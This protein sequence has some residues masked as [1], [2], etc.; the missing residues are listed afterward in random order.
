MVIKARLRIAL[1]RSGKRQAD[2]ARHCNVTTSAVNQ[3]IKDNGRE[4]IRLEHDNLMC[5][6]DLLKVS[7]DWLTGKTNNMELITGGPQKQVGRT[8]VTSCS[9]SASA[10][11]T[12]GDMVHK[13]RTDGGKDDQYAYVQSYE[14]WRGKTKTETRFMSVTLEWLESKGLVAGQLKSVEMPDDSQEGLVSKGYII[15][16]NV[17]WGEKLVNG[18]YYA[19]EIGGLITVRRADYEHNN[20]IV[21]TCMN[22]KYRDL[23]VPKND[24]PALNIIGSAVRFQGDFPNPN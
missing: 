6:A 24:V 14:F 5:V 15:I 16:V 19:I 8:Q 13:P 10:S 11:V 3:W 18:A 12:H 21:L 4:K 20:D 7:S 1:E 17:E 22:P 23:S 2:L 9:E